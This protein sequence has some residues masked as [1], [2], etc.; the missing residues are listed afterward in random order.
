MHEING[1]ME[2]KLGGEMIVPNTKVE[3]AHKV[4]AWTK[5]NRRAHVKGFELSQL[6]KIRATKLGQKN[7]PWYTI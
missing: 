1:K 5:D 6:K 4:Q 3:Q 2:G 7:K